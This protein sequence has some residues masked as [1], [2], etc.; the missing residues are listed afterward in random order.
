MRRWSSLLLAARLIAWPCLA[1]AP[2]VV[3]APRLAI[4][5]EPFKQSHAELHALIKPQ[6]AEEAWSQIPWMA[7]LWEARQKAAAAGKPLLLWEMDG[8]PLGC[9]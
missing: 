6:A 4:A 8:H 3:I 7:S 2:C 9:T 1:I 5:V